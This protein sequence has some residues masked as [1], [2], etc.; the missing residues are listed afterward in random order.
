MLPARNILSLA[1]VICAAVPGQAERVTARIDNPLE[2][3]WTLVFPAYGGPMAGATV[4]YPEGREEDLATPEADFDPEIVKQI[5][6]HYPV[7]D[8][9]I[10]LNRYLSHFECWV[11]VPPRGSVILK[12]D[13]VKPME[14]VRF[15][16]VDRHGRT[17]NPVADE[18]VFVADSRI[19][20]PRKSPVCLEGRRG[21]LKDHPLL[22]YVEGR[23]DHV[24][25]KAPTWPEEAE[26][27]RYPLAKPWNG[28][29]EFWESERSADPESR[30]AI[31][32]ETKGRAADDGADS[33]AILASRI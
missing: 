22:D 4:S 24:R 7:K 18:M 14:S 15:L 30:A 29:T 28:K 13:R 26:L 1:S 9:G 8:V 19:G 6:K 25:F 11:V 23:A 33:G 10:H 27:I 5:W 3:P 20:S 2:Q 32:L 31:G 21:P 17:G 12:L 16:L